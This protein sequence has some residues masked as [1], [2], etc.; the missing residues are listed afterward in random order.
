MTTFDLIL[1]V[2]QHTPLWV[3]PLIAGVLA[4][5]VWNLRTREIVVRRLVAFPLVML[6]LSLS[7]SIAT[8]APPALAAAAWIAAAALGAALGWA[9]TGPPLGIDPAR[10]RVRIAGSALPLV[11]TIAIVALR[12]AFGYL[13]GRHPELRAD[14]A[15]ALELI[16]AGALLAGVTFGRYGRLG[17]SVWRAW[18]ESPA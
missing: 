10:R 5:A 7:N 13:Y 15:M 1:I 2:I 14:P 18:K 16:V 6:G 9:M 12:Y 17:V 3:W 8:A 11:V 4:F